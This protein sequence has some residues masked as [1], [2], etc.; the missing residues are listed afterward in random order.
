MRIAVLVATSKP[1]WSTRRLVEALRRRGHRAL[2]VDVREAW[3]RV[4]RG[5]ELGYRGARLDP[6]VVAVRSLGT[7]IN[8]EQLM[9][10]LALLAG[11]EEAGVPVVNPWLGILYAR[12]KALTALLLRRAGLTVPESMLSESLGPL[13]RFA[14][15]QGEVVVKPLSGSLGL[16]AYRVRDTDTLFHVASLL[17]DLSRPVYAQRF[18]ER[19]GGGD[20]RAFVV[21]SR[22]VAAAERLPPPG[23]WK[24]NI[25]QGGRARRAVLSGD[26]VEAAVRAAE[27]LGLLYAGV[28]MA[29]GLD[30]NLYIFEVNAM[31]NWRGLYLATGVDPAEEIARLIEEVGKRGGDE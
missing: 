29:R 2:L 5:V 30:G 14:A 13:L 11:F 27:A 23:G 15:R 18:I 1:G 3:L 9:A 25:A 4:G 22:V 19:R 10:R 20:I 17:L 8:T 12:N 24:T 16:G 28:D 6:D 26:E 7:S 31:P 21:G